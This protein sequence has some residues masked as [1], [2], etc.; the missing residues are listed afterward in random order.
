MILHEIHA[1]RK[2]DLMVWIILF[3][4][5]FQH[6]IIDTRPR[7]I[8]S[9]IAW[10]SFR[11]LQIEFSCEVGIFVMSGSIKKKKMQ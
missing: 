3:I 2:N 5:E 4:F 7:C 6:K 8:D 10:D 11:I 9:F 1:F